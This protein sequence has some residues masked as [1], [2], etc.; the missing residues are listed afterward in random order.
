MGF[1]RFYY[2]SSVA[3]LATPVVSLPT[4]STDEDPLPSHSFSTESRSLSS[5]SAN[6]TLHHSDHSYIHFSTQSPFHQAAPTPSSGLPSPHDSTPYFPPPSDAGLSHKQLTVVIF[7]II[8]GIIGLVLLALFT[9]QAIAYA[10]LPRHN[11]TMTTAQ[12]EQLVREI[13]GYSRTAQRRSVPPPPP[14]ERAPPYE[15]WLQ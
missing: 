5:L 7:A 13:A 8:G 3:I 11:I 12:R 6:H 9:R 14:Y 10:R 1:I 2:L 15:S 4:T